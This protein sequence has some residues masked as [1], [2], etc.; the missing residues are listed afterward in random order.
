MNK[1]KTATKTHRAQTKSDKPLTLL[2]ITTHN[3]FSE[4]GIR[5]QI[6]GKTRALEKQGVRVLFFCTR[7]GGVT[8]A[9]RKQAPGKVVGAGATEQWLRQSPR[10]LRKL[11]TALATT[12]PDWVLVSGIWLC[13]WGDRLGRIVKNSGARI[14]FDMQGPVEE[15]AEYQRVL[16]SRALAKLLARWLAWAEHRFLA[17]WT[18]LIETVS[19]NAR[20]YLRDHRARFKG[21]VCLVHCGF[22]KALSEQQHA[23]YRKEWQKR[24]RID[25]T[26]PAVVFA[27]TLSG[28]QN[29][30]ALFA[31]AR[32]HRETSVFFFVPPHHHAEIRAQNRSLGLPHVHANFLPSEQLQQALCAFD[33]GLLPREETMTNTF[34]FPLKVS[35]YANARL[36]ILVTYRN[37]GWMQ[38]VLKKACLDLE[39]FPRSTKD[40]QLSQRALQSLTFDRMTARLSAYYRAQA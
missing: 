34:A 30:P 37:M 32:K 39:A 36:P 28:W 20:D 25:R 23:R 8:P 21:K 27:G 1:K 33:Y 22:D 4:N 12:K 26:R 9:M 18:D 6:G 31:F 5:S 10:L 29:K 17:R 14:S 11:T 7:F 13:L 24:L 38:G 3:L 40:F 15:I 35:E 16:G 2:V 19:H